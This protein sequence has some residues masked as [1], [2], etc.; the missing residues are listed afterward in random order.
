MNLHFIP[1]ATKNRIFMTFGA[2]HGSEHRAKSGPWF[3][4]A[5]KDVPARLE[6]GM[7]FRSEVR[8]RFPKLW[9]FSLASQEDAQHPKRRVY[10]YVRL[11]WF[12]SVDSL[13]NWETV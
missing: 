10:P 9:Q 5:L 4:L 3:E 8:Q 13:Q 7:L 12:L 2:R 1:H 11:H 6:L